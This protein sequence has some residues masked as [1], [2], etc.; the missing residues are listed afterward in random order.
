M[1][2]ENLNFEDSDIGIDEWDKT[3]FGGWYYVRQRCDRSNCGNRCKAY[4]GSCYALIS[5]GDTQLEVTDPQELWR[6]DFRVPE[7]DTTGVCPFDKKDNSFCFSFA[8]RFD[9]K[10][11]WS[12]GKND[13]F[14]IEIELDDGSKLFEKTISVSDVGDRGDSGWEVVEVALPTVP[15]GKP[16]HFGFRAS[17]TNVGDF[18]LDSIGYI[19][20][21]KIKLCD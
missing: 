21:L 20:D 14:S 2:L 6:T 11:F 17:T 3:A 1:N 8:M 19:D 12:L 13:F 7:V 5:A 16:T 10:D 15:T 18:W 4:E 9:A